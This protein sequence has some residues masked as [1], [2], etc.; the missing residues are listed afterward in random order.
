MDDSPLPNCSI[1]DVVL[2]DPDKQL[3]SDVRQASA[4]ALPRCVDSRYATA[5]DR[6]EASLCLDSRGS[7]SKAMKGLVG[8]AAQGFEDCRRNGPQPHPAEFGF[9]DSSHQRGV[10]RGGPWGGGRGLDILTIKWATRDK[11]LMFSKKKKGPTT[12]QFDDD[13]WIRSLTE[14]QEATTDIPEDSVSHDQQDVDPKTVRPIQMR[15]FLRKSV[16]RPLLALSEGEIAALT[17][18]IRQ[19]GVGTPGGAEASAIFHQLLHDEW[20]AGTLT[21]PLTL[22][23]GQSGPHR[24]PRV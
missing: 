15:E 20:D 1:R 4:M 18:S 12:K 23:A 5:L 10:C 16:S 7:I 22:S 17:T 11:Q 2:T 19:I 3:L 9:R 21:E 14:A 13:E 24:A 6:R 8:G